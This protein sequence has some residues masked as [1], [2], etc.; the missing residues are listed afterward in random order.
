MG[1]WRDFADKPIKTN[2]VFVLV[3][4]LCPTLA[5]STSVQN[6]MA[7]AVAATAVLVGSNVLISLIRTYV[8]N[9]IRIICYIVVIAG[10][11]TMVEIV[12]KA[13]APEAINQALGIFI[14]LIVVNCIILGR[15]EAFA[16]RHGALSSLL[17]GVGIGV[18]Y[19]LS[20]LGIATI[21][22]VLGAGTFW[23]YRLTPIVVAGREVVPEAQPV[24]VLVMAPGAFL[25]IG[26]LFGLFNLLGDRRREAA[27]RAAAPAVAMTAKDY[28]K[29]ETGKRKPE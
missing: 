23:G 25:V 14:P 13:R 6:G 18:G 17:D 11:V 7:M 10:F 5:V 22:E 15:A 1:L 4:G 24:T 9:Q 3:L 2:P 19:F 27:R 12:M 8:P 16:S 26:L 28:P 29:P 20:L 21:R